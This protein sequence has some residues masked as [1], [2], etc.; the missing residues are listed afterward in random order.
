M[1]TIEKNAISQY[2]RD[3]T[4]KTIAQIARQHAVTRKCFYESIN[5]G[6]SRRIRVII[7]K[8]VQIP[9]SMLWE[10]NEKDVKVVDDLHYLGLML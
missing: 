4:G 7:A 8:T 3:K 1:T 6:G 5:G 10:S 2:L 9:P